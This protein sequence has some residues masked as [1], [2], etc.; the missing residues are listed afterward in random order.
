MWLTAH[1]VLWARD[2][3]IQTELVRKNIFSVPVR[4]ESRYLAPTIFASSITVLTVGHQLQ[5]PLAAEHPTSIDPA[6]AT[7]AL[8]RMVVRTF[9]P[10]RFIISSEGDEICEADH[11]F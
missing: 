5:D 10:L 4:S 3:W 8:G 11:E 6:A 2:I 1:A 9:F 7:I